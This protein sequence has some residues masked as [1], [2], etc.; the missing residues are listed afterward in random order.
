MICHDKVDCTTED[1]ED[2]GFAII[3]QAY[4]YY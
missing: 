2:I 4:Y 1:Y 3:I